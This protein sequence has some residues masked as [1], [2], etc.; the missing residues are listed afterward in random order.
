[1][2]SEE[3]I[4]P[5]TGELVPL[6]EPDQVAR[7]LA[8]VRELKRQLDEAR[9]V[10]EEALVAEAQR[11]GTKTLRW[12]GL[13]ATVYGGQKLVWDVPKLNELR[14]AGL[15]EE[16]L[17]ELVTMVIDY[18]VDG[19]VIREL[20]GSGNEEYA[21]IV[22]EARQYVPAPWRVRVEGSDAAG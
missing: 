10:L 5:L 2:V 17:D 1:V 7:A 19:R 18:K 15:P 16:R 20:E 4:L 13:E 3:L 22:R 6:A 21:R 14:A 9:R 8:D 12:K 11:R